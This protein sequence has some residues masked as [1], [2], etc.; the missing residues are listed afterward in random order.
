MGVI[1]IRLRRNMYPNKMYV[2]KVGCRRQPIRKYSVSRLLYTH[3]GFLTVFVCSLE[4]SDLGIA[5]NVSLTKMQNP[6]SDIIVIVDF[7]GVS[8]YYHPKYRKCIRDSQR[9]SW[10]NISIGYYLKRLVNKFKS[11]FCS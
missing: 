1:P 11:V 5:K 6:R 8:H 4:C 10:V 7:Y 9:N 3:S 2:V